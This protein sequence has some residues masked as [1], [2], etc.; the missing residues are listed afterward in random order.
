MFKNLISISLISIFFLVGCTKSTN[1]TESQNKKTTTDQKT[2]QLLNKVTMPQKTNVETTT[3][4]LDN[5]DISYTEFLQTNSLLFFIDTNSKLSVVEDTIDTPYITEEQ[6]S[7]T[8]DYSVGSIT[9]INNDI[10]FSNLR[11]NNALYKLNYPKKEITK[12]L[13]GNFQNISSYKNNII[14]INKNKGST[15]NYLDIKN[16][17]I[18]SISSDKCGKYLI[19]GDYIIY[20]NLSDNSSLYSIKI[21]GSQKTKLISSPIDS[22]V[23]YQNNILNINGENNDLYIYN[24][25]A[26]TNNKLGSLHGTNLKSYNDKIFYIDLSNSNHLYQ[27]AID[28]TLKSYEST[29]LVKDMVNDYFPTENGIFIK[30][31]INS[32]RIFF[33]EYE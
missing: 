8:F 6:I 30:K 5:K 15:L 32:N 19:N 16:S 4:L 17:K 1:N 22:F 12:I 3:L 2:E 29:E 11:D 14:F 31:P 13:S 7:E 27:L 18:I 20:Q 28:D 33:I 25:I 10:F 9:S 24:P 26:K 21:D 23:T